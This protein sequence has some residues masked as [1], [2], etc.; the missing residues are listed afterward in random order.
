M[1]AVRAWGISDIGWIKKS[2]ISYFRKLLCLKNTD[3]N[4]VM[5]WREKD[6]EH[7]LVEHLEDTKDNPIG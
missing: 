3:N 5:E 4:E 6:L 2:R 1:P 7:S